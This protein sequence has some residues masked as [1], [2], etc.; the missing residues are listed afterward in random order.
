MAVRL[1]LVRHGAVI[2]PKPNCIYGAMDVELSELGRREAHAAAAHLK[3]EHLDR[4]CHSPLKARAA[5]REPKT[6]P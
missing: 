4:V 6:A 3:S 2:P 1:F 5:L